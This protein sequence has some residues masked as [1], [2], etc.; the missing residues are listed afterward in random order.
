MGISPGAFLPQRLL[1]QAVSIRKIGKKLPFGAVARR[2]SYQ[3]AMRCTA[4]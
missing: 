4:A 3:I 2:N 1:A